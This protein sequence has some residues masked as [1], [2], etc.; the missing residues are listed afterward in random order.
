MAVTGTLGALQPESDVPFEE[1]ALQVTFAAPSSQAFAQAFAPELPEFREIDGGFQLAGTTKALSLSDVRLV[2]QG[3]DGLVAEVAGRAG[4]LSLSE[5]LATRNLAL[6]LTARW[7][8]S[9]GIAK[10]VSTDL[11]ELGAIEAHAIL[12]DRDQT[13]ALNDISA[14]A[15]PTEQPRLSITG[16]IAD[17]PALRQVEL[18][19]NFDVPTS[20]LLQ[21]VAAI[22][23]VG[24]GEVHGSFDLS[25]KD[26]SLGLEALSAELEDTT[27]LSLSIRG[28][29]DDIE[30]SDELW[31]EATLTVPD[32]SQLGRELGVDAE[33]IG[34]LTFRGEVT[35]S[36]ES[37][38]AQG[39]ARVGETDLIGQLSGTM[40]GERPALRAEIYSPLFRFADLGLV[41]RADDP[42]ELVPS[43]PEPPAEKDEPADELVFGEAPIAFELLTTF[44]LDLDVMLDDIEGVRLDID[45]A[46]ARVD[47]VDGLLL[48]EPLS[49]VFVGG[50]LD[51][52]LQV[53][54]SQ[55][56]PTLRLGLAADDV[57]L[58][59][60]LLQTDVEVP[61]DGELDLLVDLSASG[62]SPRA[63]ASSLAGKFDLA[64][65][66]GH[67]R[68]SLLR[69]T[70]TNPVSWL[71]TEAARQG[72]SELNCSILRFDVQDGVAESEVVLLDTPN[73][74]ALGDGRI[75][76]RNEM[77]DIDVRPRA[78]R[79]RLIAMS[80]P[81]AIRGPLRGPSVEISTGGA[82]VRSAG[83]VLLS[84]L[85]LLGS[86]LP[87]VSDRGRDE[88]NP[89]LA[90][91]SGLSRQ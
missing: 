83:E 55:D 66:R 43:V 81:F 30:R 61:L 13:F 27:L 37:F 7:P 39:E 86:L 49:F 65:E 26:G 6:Q 23:Q 82:T 80:T 36:D 84:P 64:I 48:V 79:R 53:D 71:F 76:L 19:G 59:D 42:T 5:G 62:R 45:T 88:D 54:A 41:P 67:V 77:I 56:I 46:E 87:F 85:N 4:S 90:L 60:F 32:V 72:Y 29:F 22:Q 50:R 17:L 14:V 25:D 20:I 2:A 16:H 78:K 38:R 8:D 11:P 51:L 75:D 10:L 35:G 9:Q 68:T 28:L 89:C 70:T 21:K 40:N 47:L 73:V 34:S 58:G 18:T 1:I 15:G 63:L 69:L 3:P 91:E 52:T 44:D 74:L 31:V 57:D 12:Q 33:Q 24:L